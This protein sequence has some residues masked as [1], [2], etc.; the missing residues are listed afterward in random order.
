MFTRIGRAHSGQR[1]LF[2]LFHFFKMGFSSSQ[3]SCHWRPSVLARDVGHRAF[4]SWVSGTQFDISTAGP[5]DRLTWC[6][7]S[8]RTEPLAGG[9]RQSGTITTLT[10]PTPPSRRCQ[11]NACSLYRR[12]RGQRHS[13]EHH[14]HQRLPYMILCTCLKVE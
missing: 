4:S 13:F 7:R 3:Y 2:T 10:S 12:L 9:T 8:I 6:R 11:E 1:P 14:L 5:R